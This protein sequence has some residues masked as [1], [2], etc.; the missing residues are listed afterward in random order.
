[1][2]HKKAETKGQ[3]INHNKGAVPETNR[4][5]SATR[6]NNG[7]HAKNVYKNNPTVECDT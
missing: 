3:K 2:N 1:M 4:N 7:E 5:T 6:G